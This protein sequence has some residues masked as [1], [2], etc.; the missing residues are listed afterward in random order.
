[1][2]N[3]IVSCHPIIFYDFFGQFKNLAVIL[4]FRKKNF[5]QQKCFFKN[6]HSNAT[7]VVFHVADIC[8][9]LE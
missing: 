9:L 5:V 8:Y 2:T 3:D 7:L 6:D 1:M 4:P